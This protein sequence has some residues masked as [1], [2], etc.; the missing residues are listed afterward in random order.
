MAN[1]VSAKRHPGNTTLCIIHRV[2]GGGGVGGGAE[3]LA[4]RSPIM[5]YFESLQLTC[6]LFY[7]HGR[8]EPKKWMTAL[9]PAPAE[10]LSWWVYQM[11]LSHFFFFLQN[12]LNQRANLFPRQI[13]NSILSATYYF[14]SCFIN[15]TVFRSSSPGEKWERCFHPEWWWISTCLFHWT[16]NLLLRER[17]I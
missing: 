13:T 9:S 8:M 10:V 6:F 11:S 5:N 7:R 17:T 14:F 12:W 2:G 16:R 4:L 1:H 15:D 3:T